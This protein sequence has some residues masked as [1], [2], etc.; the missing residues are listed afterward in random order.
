MLIARYQEESHIDLNCNLEQ[1]ILRNSYTVDFAI[2]AVLKCMKTLECI[3]VHCSCM[4]TIGI[5]YGT[6]VMDGSEKNFVR[7]KI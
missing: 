3:S 1:R 2:H 6:E 7:V 5:I 4:I